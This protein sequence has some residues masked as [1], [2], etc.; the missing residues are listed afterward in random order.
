MKKRIFTAVLVTAVMLSGCGR[1]DGDTQIYAGEQAAA[2]IDELKD[3]FPDNAPEESV[4]SAALDQQYPPEP[5]QIEVPQ[6]PETPLEDLTAET[7][8]PAPEEGEVLT[9]ENIGDYMFGFELFNDGHLN[10]WE[11]RYDCAKIMLEAIAQQGAG[12]ARVDHVPDVQELNAKETAGFMTWLKFEEPVNFKVGDTVMSG[13]SLNIVDYEGRYYFYIGEFEEIDCMME[14][15]DSFIPR[16][17][18]AAE[19]GTEQ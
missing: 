1:I 2:A 12:K 10:C 11:A 4:T 7:P 3:S 19:N 18:E 9:P 14:F 8:E 16:L 6:E 15:D 17:L 5:E 13:S